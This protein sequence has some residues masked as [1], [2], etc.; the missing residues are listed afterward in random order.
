MAFQE[1]PDTALFTVECAG[2]DG[3]TPSFSLA[4][5]NSAAWLA[6][7]MNTVAAALEA[8]LVA[9]VA[10]IMP[11]D[12]TIVRVVVRDL[13]TEFGL[14]VERPAISEPGQV[15]S[16]SLP[17]EVAIRGTFL[18]TPGSPPRR[19]GVYLPPPAESQVVG[20]ILQAGPLASWEAALTALGVAMS[21]GTA[22][23]VLISRY[24]GTALV[25]GPGGQLLR[26][27]V[28]RAV[29]VTNTITGNVVSS[30]LSSQKKRRPAA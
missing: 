1:V 13:G 12:H 16:P 14:V 8:S 11:T 7:A 21:T 24:S 17:A 26:K 27:P 9:D 23:H 18:G 29:G 22:D 15:A 30:V 4:A 3:T 20:S 5:T 25:A 19:G 6:A 10:P 2:P 28:K